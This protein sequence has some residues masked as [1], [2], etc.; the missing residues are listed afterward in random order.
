[1]TDAEALPPASILVVDDEESA[2]RGAR[3]TLRAHGFEHVLTCDDPREVSS[4]LEEHRVSLLLLDLLMPHLSGEE[5]LGEVTRL[6]PELPVIVVTAE[7]DAR[8]AVRCMKQGATD[9]LLKPVT[10]EQLAETVE[11]ALEQSALRWENARLREQFFGEK[12]EHPECFE[13]ILTRDPGMLRMFGYLE[14]ISRGTHPVLITG[15]TGTGKELV[16]SALHEVSGREG[17]F[18]A[19]NVAGLDDTMF[20]DTL[21]GHTTGA[22]TGASGPR[23]GMIEQASGGTLFLDEIGDLVEASQVKL[24]RL[25]QEGEYYALGAD[26]PGRLRARVVTA[27]HRDPREFRQDLYYRLRA[28]HVRVPPL[29][30]RKGDLPLL[31]DHFLAQAAGDLDKAKPTLPPE[32]FVYLASYDFPGNVRELRSMVFDAVAR[33]G[34]GVMSMAPFLELMGISEDEDPERPDAVPGD[35]RFPY[36]MPRLRH[37]EQ[38]AVAVALERVQGNQS[39][40]ARMLGV[41]RPTIARHVQ[42]LRG[43]EGADA[44]SD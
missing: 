44:D 18:V 35:L 29:R 11:R 1:M 14:A 27:T 26:T 3:R 39:A 38:A 25:L 15:E 33:H 20:S 16:A 21:F 9:Y 22:F 31:V 19:V 28:Y 23:K 8:T 4:I 7:Q 43:E 24:L 12:V 37:L 2:L 6:H 32:L 13:K 40:A 17:N 41:S 5:V 34:Q 30:E 10:S 36:P 42:R